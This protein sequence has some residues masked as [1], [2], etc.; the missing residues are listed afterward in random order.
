MTPFWKGEREAEDARTRAARSFERL[1]QH[2]DRAMA[3]SELV[4]HRFE[5][6]GLKPADLTDDE[7]LLRLPVISKPDIIADQAPRPPYGALIG[8]DPVDVVRTYV[9]PG[10]QTTFFTADDYSATA[11]HAAWA[12]ATNGFRADDVVDVTIMYHW[13]IAGTIMDEGYRRIGCAV[14]PGGIGMVPTH[15]ENFRWLGVTGLFAFPTFL[16][17]LAN[18][19]KE[20]DVDPARD[21]SLRICTIAGEM[22]SEALR[23]RMEDFWGGMKVREI[24]GGAEVPFVAAECDRGVGMHLNPDF[25]IELLHPETREPVAAGEPGVVVATEL[26]RVAE[27]M[28]R[29]WTGDIVA[30]LNPEPC[31]CGRTTPRMGRVLGRVGEIPRVKGLFLVP[32]QIEGGL[33]RV[34]GSGRFQVVIDRPARQDTIRL[35]V[36]HRAAAAAERAALAAEMVSVVKEATRLTCE[37][38]LVEVG[39]LGDAPLIDDRRSF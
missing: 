15:L 5:S 17:E 10:P 6:A 4:R 2:A 8:C 3:S 13:V 24:Y 33:A 12:F 25:V 9:G 29:Y 26:E 1:R 14:V 19:A 23:Q 34:E 18:G 37:V 11:D 39:A 28:I 27:P 30:G 32:K 22:R 7:A 16:E 36:E 20:H 21:L 31:S 35:R 38:E